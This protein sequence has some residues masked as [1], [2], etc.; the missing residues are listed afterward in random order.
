MY[1]EVNGPERVYGSSV[2]SS[3]THLKVQLCTGHPL[4]QVEIVSVCKSHYMR[5][6]ASQSSFSLTFL[7]LECKVVIPLLSPVGV[8][9][10]V[11]LLQVQ[12]CLGA[13]AG[14]SYAGA[15]MSSA[16]SS[17]LSENIESETEEVSDFVGWTRSLGIL[18]TERCRT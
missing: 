18:L 9:V 4:I 17:L 3:L 12:E 15:G 16:I 2:F 14:M 5:W 11:H 1:S 6:L 13:G 10:Q 8:Q 7:I